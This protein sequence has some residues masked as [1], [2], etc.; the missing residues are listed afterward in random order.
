MLMIYNV[1]S[2]YYMP[3]EESACRKKLIISL[4]TLE[5]QIVGT[6]F[7]FQNFEYHIKKK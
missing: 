4:N 7:F 1:R 3:N 5:N 6:A 2:L